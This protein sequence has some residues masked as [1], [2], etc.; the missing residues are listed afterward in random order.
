MRGIPTTKLAKVN[1]NQLSRPTECC[2][3]EP[4]KKYDK[5]K[6]ESPQKSLTSFN[7]GKWDLIWIPSF[8]LALDAK[9]KGGPRASL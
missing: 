5:D 8:R 3:K 7:L 2:R 9:E 1:K 4:V 6:I